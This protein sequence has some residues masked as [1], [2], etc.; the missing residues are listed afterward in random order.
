MKALIGGS[1]LLVV[2]LSA[3]ACGKSKHHGRSPV[4]ASRGVGGDSG[5]SPALGGAGSGAGAGSGS[6]G[7]TGSGSGG[8]AGQDA[9]GGADGGEAP[10][11]TGGVAGAPEVDPAVS[12]TYRWSECGRIDPVDALPAQALYADDGSVLT[13]DRRGGIRA[14]DRENRAGEVLLAAIQEYEGY[15]FGMQLSPSGRKLVVWQ[16]APLEVYVSD[17]G[18]PIG[19]ESGALVSSSIPDRF[20]VSCKGPATFSAD[21]TI[22]VGQGSEGACLWDAESGALLSQIPF[23]YS[24]DLGTPSPYLAGVA[25]GTEPVRTMN[26]WVLRTY[27]LEGDLRHEVDLAVPFPVARVTGAVM[28]RDAETVIA[29]VIPDMASQTYELLAIDSATGV[30]LWR[31]GLATSGYDPTLNVSRDGHVLVQGSG[32]YRIDHGTP[33]VMDTPSTP[34][35]ATDFSVELGM[36]LVVGEL[37]AEWDLAHGGTS[38]LYGAHARSVYSLDLSADGRTLASHGDHAVMWELLPDFASSKPIVQGTSGPPSWNVALARDGR[39]M[40]ASGDAVA[41]FRR[42]GSIGHA[43]P[44]GAGTDCLSP[45]WAFSPAGTLMAGG[46][47][48]EVEVWSAGTLTPLRNLVADNCGG[49]VAFS[50]DGS[51]LATASLELFETATW[52]KVWDLSS[53]VTAPKP[54]AEN[55]VEF[56]PD[57]Q[58]L[59][60]TRC[61]TDVSSDFLPPGAGSCRSER[62][63]TAD[64]TELGVVPA[65]EG[66]RARYS[67]EGHWL[68]SK[69]HAF[70]VPSST[71]VEYA[72]GAVSAVFAPNGDI[73]AGLGDGALV[74]YCR[75][76]P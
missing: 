72:A 27:T 54:F 37:A 52:T 57:G 36:K 14:Y 69:N 73:I 20:D 10:G 71:S 3:V 64:G 8:A 66:D 47:S 33:V 49:G 38:A 75:S 28:S 50:P 4:A 65:L 60:V 15:D 41:F 76:T 1:T 19:A 26:N 22:V 29:V 31:T 53:E 7:R 2:A 62:Y 9:T 30:P 40:I 6:G 74:R 44:P 39:A 56:S 24:G 61:S 59:V 18:E 35:L 58:E 32:V 45:D 21:E 67:P 12:A 34:Y 68:V 5:G 42:D 13:L 70:H 43:E 17:G 23:V 11:G 48:G 51:L 63:A 25:A 16:D 46:H 55:A